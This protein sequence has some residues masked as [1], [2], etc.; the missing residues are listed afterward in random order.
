MAEALMA[1][2]ALAVTVILVA[3]AVLAVAV[4]YYAIKAFS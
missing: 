4:V 2:M 1:T 3:G